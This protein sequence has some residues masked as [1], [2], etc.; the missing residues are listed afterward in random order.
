MQQTFIEFTKCQNLY[1]TWGYK[2]I[3][4]LTEGD[5]HENEPLQ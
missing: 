3:H 4:D 5:K 1:Q 2:E